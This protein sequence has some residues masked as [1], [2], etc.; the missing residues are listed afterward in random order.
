MDKQYY[1]IGCCGID[2]GLCPRYYTEGSSRCP[3]CFG[4]N[5]AKKHPACSFITCCVKKKRL[6]VCTECNEYPCSKFSKETGEMDSFVTHRNVPANLC[7]IKQNGL[8][9]FITQQKKRIEL[10]EMLLKE[11]DDGKSKSFYC[12]ACTLLSI[13]SLHESVYLSRE[14]IISKKIADD[15]KK[16]KAQIIHGALNRAADLEKVELKLRKP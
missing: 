9:D 1:T 2:C 7:F 14:E 10:L 8:N 3:G 15:D 11:Y 12:I 13:D 5:F 4:K 16:S 6:E